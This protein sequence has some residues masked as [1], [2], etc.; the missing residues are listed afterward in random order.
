MDA[1]RFGVTFILFLEVEK[2]FY[3]LRGRGQEKRSVN[4]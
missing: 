2:P 3:R 1:K 4:V